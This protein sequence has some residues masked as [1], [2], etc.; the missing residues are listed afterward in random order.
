MD[1]RIAIVAAA[2]L[3]AAGCFF[4]PVALPPPPAPGTYVIKNDCG[5][6]VRIA[7]GADPRGPSF[8]LPP[9][10]VVTQPWAP[11]TSI[12]LVDAYGRGIAGTPILPHRRRVLVPLTCLGLR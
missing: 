9:Y 6:P 12:W 3:I 2:A 1:M 8:V 11:G 4:H 5:A 7:T 10:A